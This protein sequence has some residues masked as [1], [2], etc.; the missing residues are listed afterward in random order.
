MSSQL[1][2]SNVSG[3]KSMKFGV[4]S[5]SGSFKNLPKVQNNLPNSRSA[6][7]LPGE[8]KQFIKANSRSSMSRVSRPMSKLDGNASSHGFQSA[9]NFEISPDKKEFIQMNPQVKE[10]E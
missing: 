10:E 4:A 8:Q 3:S 2:Q 6:N 1:N 5:V 9:L 7:Q